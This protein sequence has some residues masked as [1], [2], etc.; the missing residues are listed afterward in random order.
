MNGFNV[1]ENEFLL[2]YIPWSKRIE[3]KN[4]ASTAI[5][6]NLKKINRQILNEQ[7]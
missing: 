4:T 6:R 3:M 5:L 1:F 2:E 7:R